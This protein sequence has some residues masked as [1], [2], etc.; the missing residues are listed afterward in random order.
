MVRVG[1]A[2]LVGEVGHGVALVRRFAKR[3]AKEV[4]RVRDVGV[5]L[6]PGLEDQGHVVVR[7]AARRRGRLIEAFE[8]GHRL[9]VLVIGNGASLLSEGREGGD[10]R[11]AGLWLNPRAFEPELRQKEPVI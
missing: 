9:P 2:G 8:G 10:G 3:F 5:L 4:G 7:L 1:G 11:L 6:L